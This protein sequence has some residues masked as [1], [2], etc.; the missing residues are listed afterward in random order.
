MNPHDARSTVA[1]AL[2]EIVPDADV[3]AFPADAPLR[4][5]LELDSL[6]FLTFVELLSSRAQVRI[7]ELD[8]PRLATLDSSVAFLVERCA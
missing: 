1:D 3:D 4:E 5:E 2:T 8:Y 6:D 7:D